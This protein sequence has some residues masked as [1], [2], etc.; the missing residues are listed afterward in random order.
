VA[1]R[2][3]RVHEYVHEQAGLSTGAVADNNELSADL[4]HGGGCG[5]VVGVGEAGQEFCCED[6]GLA[7][8]GQ[9]W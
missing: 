6:R 9:E 7:D 8:D 2:A 4:S 3:G 5:R 1:A